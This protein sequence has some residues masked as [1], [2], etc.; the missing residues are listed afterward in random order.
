M[1]VYNIDRKANFVD[2]EAETLDDIWTL[3]LIL[4]NGDYVGSKSTRRFRVEGT[5]ES[6]KKTVFVKIF[7]EKKTLDLELGSLK[8]TGIIKYGTPAEYVDINSY[9]SID[10]SPGTRIGIEKTKFMKYEIDLI[11]KAKQN[12]MLPKIY[13]LVLDDDDSIIAK[14]NHSRYNTL[15][16][17]NSGKSG[18]RM[19]SS[20]Y[21]N[22]YFGQIYSYLKTFDIDVVIVAGPGFE[23]EYFKQFLQDKQDYK[24]FY[25]TNINST[26]VTGINELIKGGS[27]SN[28]LKDFSLHKDTLLINNLLKE[29]A[30]QGNIT[31]GK[32]QVARASIAGAIEELL[33][34]DSFIVENYQDI[35]NI[36][37][38][39][40]Q[41]N[42]IFHIISSQTEAGKMLQSLGGI[43]AKLYYKID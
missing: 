30:M 27:L 4:Q 6:E 32:S 13:I 22:S 1:K 7:L 41:S 16:T 37:Y 31:Y 28:I 12:I 39:I 10:I 25:F 29:I 20:A 40:E 17:I 23:K 8:I 35:K 26:G 9:H 24:K 2:L 43:A 34:C 21:R 3:N 42:G 36:I 18:K 11:E 15:G 19:E 5:T 38:N 14:L 33:V